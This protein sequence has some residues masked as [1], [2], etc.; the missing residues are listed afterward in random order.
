MYDFASCVI[1]YCAA[2]CHCNDENT[3]SSTNY[4]LKEENLY[5]VT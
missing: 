2:L 3:I 5:S 1:K 4:E